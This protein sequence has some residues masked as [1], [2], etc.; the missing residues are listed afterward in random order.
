M[1]A[2]MSTDMAEI[3]VL[4]SEISADWAKFSGDAVRYY[5]Q[6]LCDNNKLAD[7]CMRAHPAARIL[8]YC[9]YHGNPH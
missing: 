3:M 8:L 1:L 6:N 4:S 7:I 2:E 5:Q 9:S